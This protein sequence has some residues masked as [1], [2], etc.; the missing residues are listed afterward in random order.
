MKKIKINVSGMHCHSCE[1]LVSDAIKELDGTNNIKVNHK[2][3]T[4]EL[5]FNESKV[6]FDKIKEVIEKEGYKIR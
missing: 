1:M 2:A 4:V 3:G 6:N 5:E